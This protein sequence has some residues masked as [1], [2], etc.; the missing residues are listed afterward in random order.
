M[1][2]LT[3]SVDVSACVSAKQSKIPDCSRITVALDVDVSTKFLE[4]P[5]V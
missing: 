1:F 2:A 3:Q 4:L 5:L